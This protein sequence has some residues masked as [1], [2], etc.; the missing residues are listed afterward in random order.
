MAKQ[1]KEPD[2]AQGFGRFMAEFL[3]SVEYS[4]KEGKAQSQLQ[5]FDEFA[6]AFRSLTMVIAPNI[7]EIITRK[8][9]EQKVSSAK[10]RGHTHM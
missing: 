1:N 10:Q 9:V 7:V 3:A 4:S 8:H 2:I 5:G 6:S